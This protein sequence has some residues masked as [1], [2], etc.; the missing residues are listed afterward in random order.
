MS[1][2]DEQPVAT[3]SGHRR[4]A[5]RWPF[6]VLAL[7]VVLAL[8]LAGTVAVRL[9]STPDYPGAGAGRVV[10]QVHPGDSATDI[11]VTLLARD[12]V[13]SSRAFRKAAAADARARGLQPGYYALRSRMSGQ[14]ALALLLDPAARLRS[15]VVL[16]EG[17]TLSR[18]LILIAKGTEIP[19][20][21]LTA[22]AAAPA[23]L[24]LPPYARNRLEGLLFPASY[25]VEPGTTA[26]SLLSTMVARFGEAALEADLAA[27]AARIGRTPYEVLIVASLI[28]KET[29]FAADRAKVARVVYNRL[30]LDMPLQFDSTVNYGKAVP[31]A[32]LSNADLLVESPYNTY[33]HKGLPPTPIDAPGLLALQ[34]ALNPAEGD[35]V[36]FVTI[37]KDGRSLFT[38]SYTEFLAAKATSQREGVY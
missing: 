20:A 14:A 26:T 10:V 23:T 21:E 17:I 30:K 31:T 3:G 28:E 35:Y 9:L 1:D 27:G 32:R 34:A 6:L 29:A 4:R 15:R 38:R 16:P 25:D 12:V 11:A 5:P 36:F 37:S 2:L 8:A 7:V 22:A 19:L 33:L 13:K 18:A 24:G